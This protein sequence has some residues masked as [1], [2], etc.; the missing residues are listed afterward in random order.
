MHPSCISLLFPKAFHASLGVFQLEKF[1]QRMMGTC[2]KIQGWILSVVQGSQ[3]AQLEFL[4]SVP[5]GEALQS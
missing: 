3:T 4:P 2:R 5:E 1:C